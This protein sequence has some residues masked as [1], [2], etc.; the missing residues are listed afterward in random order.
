MNAVDNK[1]NSVAVQKNEEFRAFVPKAFWEKL[2]FESI[3]ERARSSKLSNLRSKGLL[4]DDF[5]IRLWNGFGLTL[6]QGF[7]LKRTAGEWLAVDLDWEVSENKPGKRIPKQID[8]KLE[9][10]KSGW[11]TA[12][13]KLIDAEILTLPDAKEINCEGG[14]TD[15]ISFVVEYNSQNTYRTYMYDNPNVAKCE[16]AKRMIEI[17]KIIREEFYNR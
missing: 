1:R 11:T 10:P 15:G 14:A 17:V 2:Y 6:L 4:K 8:R 16:E 12:W 3:N 7:I 13:Q 5:E 9:A